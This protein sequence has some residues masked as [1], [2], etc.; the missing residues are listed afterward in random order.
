MV[1]INT[2]DKAVKALVAL[3][4][5]EEDAEW[6]TAFSGLFNGLTFDNLSR[7]NQ[8][9]NACV[10]EFL[11]R[12]KSADIPVCKGTSDSQQYFRELPNGSIVTTEP[13]VIDG[14]AWFR[15]SDVR[16]Q[17]FPVY[18][19]VGVSLWRTQFRAPTFVNDGAT[20]NR[21]EITAG[22][23]DSD[24]EASYIGKGAVVEDAS[25]LE[26]V[27]L[28]SRVNGTIS[29]YDRTYMHGRSATRLIMGGSSALGYGVTFE[30]HPVAGHV[31]VIN[32]DQEDLRAVLQKGEDANQT[33]TIIGTNVRIG[34]GA[35]ITSPFFC[36]KNSIV[37][38]LDGNQPTLRGL[39][40][41]GIRYRVDSEGRIAY[42]IRNPEPR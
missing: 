27:V 8:N 17:G 35:H 16:F 40:M 2:M 10:E 18:L 31:Y 13:I 3:T 5:L 15:E 37:E 19:G 6:P 30:G 1:M 26:G 23:K 42:T 39:L 12:A 4:G 25:K 21:T 11:R 14:D 38:S 34:D 24:R 41:N 7:I 9:R 33:P 22:R 36:Q 20:L 32:P 28:G 29:G